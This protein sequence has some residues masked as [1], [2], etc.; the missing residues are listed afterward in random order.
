M[1]APSAGRR[2]EDIL[3]DDT[4]RRAAGILISD[5]ELSPHAILP[6]R[7]VQTVARVVIPVRAESALDTDVVVDTASGREEDQRA[8]GRQA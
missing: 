3:L 7:N 8:R 5:G 6:L 4:R 2:C 1:S